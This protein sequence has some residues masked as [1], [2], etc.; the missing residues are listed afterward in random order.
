MELHLKT[1][2]NNLNHPKRV[3]S[4]EIS[5]I[6]LKNIRDY[7]KEIEADGFVFKDATKPK[8]PKA[9][10]VWYDSNPKKWYRCSQ[11]STQS[12]DVDFEIGCQRYNQA[13][14]ERKMALRARFEDPLTSARFFASSAHHFRCASS[15]VTASGAAN[16]TADIRPATLKALSLLVDAEAQEAAVDAA[17]LDGVEEAVKAEIAQK[18][19][20]MFADLARV[21]STIK[22]LRKR[23]S[24][25][26][27]KSAEMSALAQK[28]QARVCESDSFE[29][30]SNS[31]KRGEAI[32]RLIAAAEG[33]DKVERKFGATSNTRSE[34][35]EIRK[36]LKKVKKENDTIFHERIPKFGEIPDV[37]GRDW[38]RQ[39]LWE[40]PDFT[41]SDARLYEAHK[42]DIE[43]K[44]P[45]EIV[46][47]PKFF[48][49][50]F[51]RFDVRQGS[52]GDCWF[53]AAIASLANNKKAFEKTVPTNQGFGESYNGKFYFN[54]WWKEKPMRIGI[55]DRLPVTR[56]G[57]IYPPR[58][59]LLYVKLND[60]QE[61]W[62]AL[63]EKAVAKV[64]GGYQWLD[65]GLPVNALEI[66]TG[67]KVQVL[68]PRDH[69]DHPE[70]L[71][72][73][74]KQSHENDAI[75]TCGIWS[76]PDSGRRLSRDGLQDGHAY[77]VT[78]VATVAMT[79]GD[80]ANLI[81]IRNPWGNSVE[82]KHSWADKSR[83]WKNVSADEKRRLDFDRDNDGEFWMD[84]EDFC[85]EFSTVSICKPR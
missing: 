64:L 8:H 60:G 82:W 51:S 31:N 40:D 26:A 45:S 18:A 35:E 17:I 4:P 38:K 77:S 85:S 19:A 43:W 83:K 39:F 80:N 66:L 13:V 63:I 67:G 10:F 53:L 29:A 72:D 76:G 68:D 34:K 15:F 25:L 2:K 44:R 32:A 56:I 74:L 84:I 55:D 79:T 9:L 3:V 1:S 37:V 58:Y 50:G 49:D 24:V 65:G 30:P 12:E 71:F 23:K 46:K 73:R 42:Y 78:N 69:E 61:F 47:N 48:V 41:P 36:T 6:T 21:S 5:E 81:R 54:L 57:S 70:G 52:L 16:L 11:P 7:V 62:P 14:I 27:A 59:E 22:C 20:W 75:M 28:F 33:M